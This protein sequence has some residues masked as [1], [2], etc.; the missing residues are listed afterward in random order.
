M[1]ASR[2]GDG[3]EASLTVHRGL[4]VAEASQQRLRCAG[5]AIDGELASGEHLGGS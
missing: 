3:V 4:D 2:H 5:V 1:C